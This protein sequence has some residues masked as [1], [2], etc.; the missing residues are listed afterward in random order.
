MNPFIVSGFGGAE[1]F[2]GRKKE[3]KKLKEAFENRRNVTMFSLRRMG[4]SALV[5]YHFEKTAKYADCFYADLFPSQ[6]FDD[7]TEII[8]RSITGQSK[9]S[10]KQLFDN[11]VS[12]VRSMGASLSFNDLTGS[13]EIN[14]GFNK[15]GNYKKNLEEILNILEKNKK[16][17]LIALDEFQ[18]VRTFSEKNTE[19]YLRS[20]IQN[21]KNVNFI[22]LGSNNSII[23]SIFSDSKKPFYQSTQYMM[24]DEIGNEEYSE[25]IMMQFRKG[26]I[27]ISESECEL[28]LK[29]CR[30]HTYYVQYLCNRLYSKAVHI[31]PET[32][33]SVLDEI[34]QENEPVFLNYKNLLTSLQW[35]LAIAIAKE[36][37]VK[38]PLAISFIKKYD[39]NSASSLKRA[40]DALLKKEII[41]YYKEMYQLNDLFFSLW[42]KNYTL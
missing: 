20:V 18:I 17:V 16:K 5:K 28:I 38:E 37:K 24:L 32:V 7:M 6:S 10:G 2:C 3:L 39:L 8:A 14:F 27:K 19:A 36:D 29:L 30:T 42:L 34:L 33:Y 11:I 21:L 26:K 13:P 4:K 22:F 35:K 25:F 9:L 23:E 41:V 1:Y 40:L 31:S 12:I 15:R